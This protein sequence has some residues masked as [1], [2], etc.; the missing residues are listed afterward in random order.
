MLSKIARKIKNIGE[1]FSNPLP[2]EEA[3]YQKRLEACTGC[4]FNS[5]NVEKD[6][7]TFIHKVR[8]KANPCPEKRH[9]TACGC[10][11]DRKAAVPAEMCGIATSTELTGKG[12]KPLWDSVSIDSVS[13]AITVIKDLDDN[14]DL[15]VTGGYFE[16]HLGERFG[17]L[18]DFHYEVIT[19]KNYEIEN[20]HTACGCTSPE[21]VKVADG[22]FKFKIRIALTQLKVNTQNSKT[23]TLN[24]KSEDKRDSAHFRFILTPLEDDK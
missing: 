8:D 1:A 17:N 16:I 23:A 11:I 18:C 22:H 12:Y 9:C 20:M 14:Y 21:V 15:K 2:V 3:W 5:D 7:K 19:P 4:E 10:C 24:F 13:G 6:K